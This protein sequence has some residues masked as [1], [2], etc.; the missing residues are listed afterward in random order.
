MNERLLNTLTRLVLTNSSFLSAT[1]FKLVANCLKVFSNKNVKTRRRN[2]KLNCFHASHSHSP[3]RFDKPQ[4]KLTNSNIHH[5]EH[6]CCNIDFL[7]HFNLGHFLLHYLQ[8]PRQLHRIQPLKHLMRVHII[9][10][11]YLDANCKFEQLKGY[12]S[13]STIFRSLVKA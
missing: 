12:Q 1:F 8:T 5:H 9:P 3:Y 7:M 6:H 2:S 10:H 11:K 13:Q 4:E